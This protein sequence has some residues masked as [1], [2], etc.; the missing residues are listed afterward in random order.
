MRKNAKLLIPT[1]TLA[2]SAALP[3][4]GKKD[5]DSD[6]GTVDTATKNAGLAFT[7]VVNFT[8][9]TI[10]YNDL[11]TGELRTLA[12]GES[13]DPLLRWLG[14]SLVLFNR[15]QDK[16][17]FKTTDPRLADA[18][19]STEI[20]TPKAAAFDPADAL[21]LGDGRVL[22]VHAVAGLLVVMDPATGTVTQEITAEWDVGDAEG[23]KLFPADPTVVEKDG[24]RF[25]Y[26]AHQAFKPDYSGFNGTQQIFV[27]KDTGSTLEVVDLD[28]EKAK[29]QGI[30]LTLPNPTGLFHV[31]DTELY[32]GAICTSMSPADCRQG[33]ERVSLADGTATLHWE[34]PTTEHLLE[35]GLV[36]GLDDQLFAQ[37]FKIEG[38]TKTPQVVRLDLS[39]KSVTTVHA[40]GEKSRA[41][42]SLFF[43][44]S[45]ETL[46]AGDTNEDSTGAFYIYRKG[47]TEPE[48]LS[49]PAAPYTGVFVPE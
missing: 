43:D 14:E 26:L 31:T 6:K 4:C 39:D 30:P 11:K 22:L 18:Q 41:C 5:D 48:T 25:V 37:V 42:C 28:A 40:Y 16:L 49:L 32:V 9:S 15:S 21:H 23:A 10:H 27:L 17:N 13:G 29:V 3:G 19:F 33:F 35:G 1:V 46:Y 24:E 12:T 7:T 38:E 36:E 45:S 47:Q 2:L 8:E 44:E 34:I 20:A